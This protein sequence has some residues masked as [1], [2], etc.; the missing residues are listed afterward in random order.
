[1][2]KRSGTVMLMLV[3]ATLLAF[4][5]DLLFGSVKVPLGDFFRLIQGDENSNL[6][7]ILWQIRLPKALTA[8]LAGSGLAVCGLLMQTLFRNPLAGPYVLGISSGASLGVALLVMASSWFGG[9]ELVHSLPYGH[10][11]LVIAAMGGALLVML[12]VIMVS[13]RLTD[14]VSILIIGIMFGSA[15]G[16]V[17]NV[18]QY[19][20]DPDSVHNFVVWTFGSISGVTWSHLALLA[21]LITTGLL[22]S[23]IL[24]KPL[25]AILLG[26]NQART[27]GIRIRSVRL[28]IITI[29]SLITGALTAFT[30]PIAFIGVAVPHL[31]RAIFQTSD[32]RVILPGS[33]LAG[34]G[35]ML[36]CDILAQV[37]ASNQILP[38]NTVTSLIGAPILIWVVIRSRRNRNSIQT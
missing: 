8:I 3:G 37:P 28:A 22:V 1:M 10:W 18:L 27:L 20:S 17:V 36:L 19:F 11:G 34:S 21:P 9:Q 23:F 29:T 32:H 38:V 14:A 6:T 7:Y 12:L 35:L 15:T 4:A 25:N 30:G 2:D 33:I 24:Q 5:G 31:A 16:A 13:A 26:E